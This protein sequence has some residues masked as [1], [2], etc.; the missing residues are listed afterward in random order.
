MLKKVIT[1]LTIMMLLV[2]V[3]S[4]NGEITPEE[5]EPEKYQ[6]EIYHT[7]IP[8]YDMITISKVDPETWQDQLEQNYLIPVSLSER[9]QETELIDWSY[10]DLIEILEEYDLLRTYGFSFL[11]RFLFF[12]Q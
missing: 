7:I 4:C 9:L 5:F 1:L 11:H 10:E 3:T 12:N 2:S 8:G 6:V